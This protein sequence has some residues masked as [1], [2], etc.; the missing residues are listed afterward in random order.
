MRIKKVQ[1]FYLPLLI[2]AIGLAILGVAKQAQAHSHVDSFE[3]P[4]YR[5]A[6]QTSRPFAEKDSNDNWRGV[7]PD[8][9][10]ALAERV[11]FNYSFVETYTMK[12]LLGS[13]RSGAVDIAAASLSITADREQY[14]DFSHPYF[15]TTLGMLTRSS[16]WDLATI[17]R[18]AVNV[19]LVLFVL[20][21]LMYAVGSFMNWWDGDG[22]IRT[23]HEGAY[24]ALTTLTTVGYGDYAPDTPRGR[25]FASVWMVASLFLVSIFTGVIAS[26]FTVT[27]L[28]RA[29]ANADVLSHSRVATLQGTTGYFALPKP[30]FITVLTV[31]EGLDAIDNDVV[32][33]LVHDKAI[34]DYAV[35]DRDGYVVQVFGDRFEEYG[36]AYTQDSEIREKLNIALIQILSSDGWREILNRYFQ[37]EH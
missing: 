13:V 18:V 3:K 17:L 10:A 35:R 28:T 33:A 15:R 26:Y 27:S 31:E 1:Y 34:L 25:V 21:T 20:A 5:I 32:D 12:Q 4:H 19:A 30:P 11:N 8:L 2:I 6:I 7:T 16:P 36:L 23:N 29:P 14:V 9:I 24:W 22:S 37:K